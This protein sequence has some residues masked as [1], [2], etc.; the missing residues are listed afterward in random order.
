MS[1]EPTVTSRMDLSAVQRWRS[2]DA[3]HQVAIR[4][5]NV[6]KRYEIYD[7]PH[8][9]LKQFVLP[10]LQ[11]F[12]GKVP[13]QYFHEF[14]ALKDIS[15]EIAKGETVGVIGRNGS[16]KSTLLQI[17]CG[18]LTPTSGSVETRGRVAALL[19]LGAGFNPEFTGRENVYLNGAIL[20]L[21]K[22]EIDTRF[23]S[24]AAFAD[25]G[26]FMEQPVKTYSSGMYVRLAFAVSINVDPDILIV[27]EALSVGDARFQ[28]KC[29]KRIKNIQANG[30]TILFVSHDV[31][32]VRTLC[33]RALWLDGGA[34]RMDGDVFP[35]TGSFMEYLFD[36]DVNEL[37]APMSVSDTGGHDPLSSRQRDA[38]QG[39][40]SDAVADAGAGYDAKPV[41]HWGSHIGCIR[42]AGLFRDDSRDDVVELG[43]EVEVRI[44]FR[45][46]PGADRK[47]LSVAF[48]LKDLKGTDLIVSSTGDWSSGVFEREGDIYIASF[49]FRNPLV[50]GRYLLVAAIEDRSSPAIHYYEYL[51][52]AHYFSSVTDAR[53]FGIFQPDI[54]Q[55]VIELYE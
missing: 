26:E 33:E 51:E 50:T 21:S 16:G 42:S 40:Y 43:D 48:A 47:H 34:L 13:A 53:L 18:T 1:F 37:A 45:V 22:A 35:V 5:T 52:G 46:P 30:T 38:N 19:E 29:M 23:D 9:R 49:R 24:I 28:A 44:A 8:E 12:V 32:S 10:K 11:R 25:I 17:I 6:S 27:D 15:F 14:C 2:A 54:Q 39:P 55:E 31:S 4:A 3:A 41:T 7:T 36:G 20:G